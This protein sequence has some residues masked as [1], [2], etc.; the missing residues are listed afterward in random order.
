MFVD[1]KA[2]KQILS[3]YLAIY[4]CPV[5]K[6]LHDCLTWVQNQVSIAGEAARNVLSSAAVVS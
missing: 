6:L 1:R 2:N 5:K 4:N 3:I